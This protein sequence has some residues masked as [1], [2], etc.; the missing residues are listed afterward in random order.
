MMSQLAEMLSHPFMRH[1]FLAGLPS[2]AL[3]GAVGYFMV[4]RGQVFTGDALSHVAFSGA[5]TA[6]ALGLD[7]RVGL[8]AGTIA[9]GVVLAAL[10]NRGQA[11]DIVI[12]T[13]F[14]WV[15]GL[16]VLALS[17]YATSAR[18]GGNGVA[19]VRILFGSIFGLSRGAALISAG[20][21]VVLLGLGAMI[22][23]PLLFASLDGAVAAGRGV[24]VRLLGIGFL[25][26]VGAT[27][28]E[29]TQAVGALLLLGLLSAPAGAAHRLTTRPWTGLCTSIGLAVLS[30][31]VGL[32]ASFLVPRVPPSFA[33]VSAAALCYALSFLRRS[34]RWQARTSQV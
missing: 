20:V 28:A 8:F 25:V 26:L 2:A 11:D 4:L 22:A 3:A 27:A 10:G 1:A 18:S 13:V 7:P 32:I 24:P 17:V 14:A 19:G 31:A 21:A 9:V 5:L 29:T 33:I 30:T 34:T 12:G 23:R 15:L 16:G 6:L